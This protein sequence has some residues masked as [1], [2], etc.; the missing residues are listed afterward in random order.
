M[1]ALLV[2]LLLLSSLPSAVV[3]GGVGLVPLSR[4]PSPPRFRRHLR[5]RARRAGCPVW[6]VACIVRRRIRTRLV[7][8]VS[9]VLRLTLCF[10]CL[11][12]PAGAATPVTEIF[13]DIVVRGRSLSAL[14]DT[15]ATNTVF[16]AAAV[17]FTGLT[18]S[19]EST[20][21]TGFAGK[22]VKT[23]GTVTARIE[24]GS[25]DIDLPAIPVLPRLV[26]GAQVIFGMDFLSLGAVSIHCGDGTMTQGHRRVAATSPSIPC[27]EGTP[28]CLAD[29]GAV[30]AEPTHLP[31]ARPGVDA[32]IILKPGKVLSPLKP[33]SMTPDKEALC[34]IEL[35]RL[36]AAN[37]IETST[38]AYAAPAFFVKDKAS[39]SRGEAKD[40]MVIDYRALNEA[41][42][43]TPPC[44]P[45]LQDLLRVCGPEAAIFSKIDL[46]WGF[47]NLRLTPRASDLSAF[48][49]PLGT[50]RYKVMPFGIKNGPAFM[51]HFMRSILG[52][53]ENK[54]ITIY[55]DDILVFSRNAAEHEAHLRAVFQR[56]L[57]NDCH[58]RI[59]KCELFQ[60]KVNF[61][62][63]EIS[64]GTIAQ[65]VS[66]TQAIHDYAPPRSLKGVQRF[67]G[68][69]NYY[70]QFVPKFS[71]LSKP[72]TR[73]TQKTTPFVWDDAAQ[74]AFDRIKKR[75]SSKGTLAILDPMRPVYLQTDASSV[76]WAAVV[77]QAVAASPTL[78]PIAFIS[79]TFTETEQN[80]D[81][82]NR[83]LAAIVF[84]CRKLPSLLNGPHCTVLCDHAS[85]QTIYETRITSERQA[86]WATTLMEY[87]IAIRYLPGS[88]NVVADALSRPE[89]VIKDPLFAGRVIPAS[90][91]EVIEKSRTTERMIAAIAPPSYARQ[92]TMRGKDLSTYLCRHHNC[93]NKINVGSILC[94][95]HACHSW[96]GH[97]CAEYAER[98]GAR[99]GCCRI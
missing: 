71:D 50:F 57:E 73:L 98:T 84:A 37:F 6:G 74:D 10:L 75:I 14:V 62:G 44:L 38:A 93:L 86:R 91:P 78:R 32:D 82:T 60:E 72:L 13:V 90:F 29:F 40:R 64:K 36:R 85:L 2:A 7:L 77:S 20:T 89:G 31:P 41:T 68:L 5:L 99:C 69:A 26:H 19:R 59:G 54:C 27:P 22:N 56:L 43:S 18:L 67:M 4:R 15:G 47:N 25:L 97:A 96:K 48:T 8:P 39:S 9:P 83:E 35:D 94:S 17:A 23:R 65:N 87:D 81:T 79:G 1:L 34:R 3:V 55:L 24:F 51:Q 63:F 66:N 42:L 88:E 21:L 53:L 95:M 49:T 28:E 70:A 11:V 58:V 12:A 45:R 16:S 30:F 33:I 80:W 76:A 61:V 92:V 46:R 52:D